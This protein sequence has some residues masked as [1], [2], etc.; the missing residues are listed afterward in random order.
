MPRP[1]LVDFRDVTLRVAGR[2]AFAHTSW[3]FAPGQQWA[4][5]GA[6]GA[7]KSTFLEAV[8]GDVPYCAGRIDYGLDGRRRREGE[9]GRGQVQLVSA[10]QHRALVVAALDFHQARWSPVDAGRPVTVG[11]VIGRRRQAWTP[12]AGELG[13]ESL[14]RRAVGSLSNGEM[15]K[16]LLSRA[17][18]AAPRLLLLDS[19]FAGL[20]A[21]SRRHL[22]AILCRRM[23]AGLPVLMA[24]PR[25]QELPAP[26]THVL[27]LENARVSLQGRKEEVLGQP[28]ARRLVE[29]ERDAQ[30]A[31]TLVW[32]KDGSRRTAD[33]LPGAFRAAAGARLRGAAHRPPRLRGC[34][35]DS[36]GGEENDSGRG[37]PRPASAVPPLID[38]RC[39]DVTYDRVR[40]LRR[41]TWTVRAGQSWVLRGRNGS[42]KST[43]LSLVTGDN[44]QGYASDIRLFGV[45]RGT[46]ES[47]WEIKERIGWLA[48]ELQFHYCGDVTCWEVVCSGLHDTVGLY[49]DSSPRE[50]RAVGR[51]LRNLELEDLADR[52]FGSLS[53]GQQRL[54]LLARALVKEPPLLLFD[55][56]CQGLDA[57]HRARVLTILDQVARQPLT[58][59]VYVTHHADEIPAA[60]GWELRLGRGRVLY[61]GRRRRE[62]RRPR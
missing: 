54:V 23:R 49:R 8:L 26:I 27:F 53:D 32:R 16:V 48:P 21:A 5:V 46:G 50:A 25:P 35:G 4:V 57:G 10:D 22:R 58:T 43:L 14:W 60:F 7:G 37:R 42:G 39:A 17:L 34:C 40:V 12:V 31:P 41:V 52:P 33:G 30:R 28:A 11:Q 47:I 18:L 20:D 45:P 6:T 15:R 36:T 55:E 51:W 1:P 24:A 61:R 62:R 13:I 9:Y 3:T 38:I 29:A 19:P 56:P 59:V 2:D 44:P